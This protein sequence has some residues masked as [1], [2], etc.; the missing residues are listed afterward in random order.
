M[1]RS[2][3]NFWSSDLLILETSDAG[4]QNL[5]SSYR[6]WGKESKSLN[7][8]WVQ[9]IMYNTEYLNFQKEV[10]SSLQYALYDEFSWY[11]ILSDFVQD[12]MIQ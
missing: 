1:L 11:K 8:S 3:A 6:N 5:G 10:R 2:L 7:T 4:L 12:C 9:N